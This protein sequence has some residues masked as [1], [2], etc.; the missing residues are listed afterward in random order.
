MGDRTLTFLKASRS[1]L[2]GPPRV[3]PTSSHFQ[4]AVHDSQLKLTEVL[5]D[6]PEPHSFGLAK[7]PR[8]PERIDC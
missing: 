2:S 7:K 6:E 5:V 3:V 8:G 1:F 4:N